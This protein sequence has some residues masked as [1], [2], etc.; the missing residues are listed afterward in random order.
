MTDMERKRAYVVD[1]YPGD[2]WKHRV[3]KM[4]D[5]RVIAIYLAHQKDGK[6]PEHDENEPLVQPEEP[7]TL[8]LMFGP[9]ANEDEFPIY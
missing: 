7:Q 3:A 9:H 5:D 1:L 2:R 4:T 8:P 6:K